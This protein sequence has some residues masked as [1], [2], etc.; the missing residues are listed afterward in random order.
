M[1]TRVIT[2]AKLP[3]GKPNYL[4]TLISLSTRLS[5]ATKMVSAFADTTFTFESDPAF[6]FEMNDKVKIDGKGR[7][8]TITIKIKWLPGMF[9]E[10]K[11][12]VFQQ[13]IWSHFQHQRLQ[14][15]NEK[16][17]VNKCV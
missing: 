4:L 3:I 9:R 1:S 6:N 5:I 15:V 8:N 2:P 7:H 10:L 16:L 17:T 13:H 12:D 14:T 11:F